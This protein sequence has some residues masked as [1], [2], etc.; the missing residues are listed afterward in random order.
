M[1]L[2]RFKQFSRL[3]SVVEK[4]PFHPAARAERR[5]ITVGSL[6]R[7]LTLYGRR[8]PYRAALIVLHGARG[9][10]EGVRRQSGHA[11]DRL[12]DSEP[13]L[14][15]YPD[16]FKEH[17]ND[18]RRHAG[19]AT[20]REGIDDI[21]FLRTL[22]ASLCSEFALQSSSIYLVGFSNGGHLVY[23]ALSAMPE[24]LGGAVIIGANR[25]IPGH[26]VFALDRL[27]H[28]VLLVAGDY[29]PINPYHGGRTTLFGLGY[30]GNVL[31]A[32]DSAA[33]LA[34]L[35]LSRHPSGWVSGR[36]T[37]SR[38]RDGM[39][40]TIDYSCEGAVWVRLLRL[41]GAGH[42]IPQSYAEMPRML[43]DTAGGID[44]AR[45]AWQFFHLDS[46]APPIIR[47]AT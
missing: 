20:A 18:G 14:V 30:R 3:F 39:I 24:S 6:A 46:H 43:G 15:V 7:T 11:F 8:R 47:R 33:E 12:A 17:W 9:S 25:S 13:C 41:H 16:G 35:A 21:G 19:F 32:E 38:N 28:P 45:Y 42:T 31:S 4:T 22:I 5:T 29:D 36:M 34:W 10:G 44:I 37:A 1:S 2:S 26:A 40:S 27:H 23:R